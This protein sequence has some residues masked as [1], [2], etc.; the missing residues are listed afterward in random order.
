MSSE[1]ILNVLE[2]IHVA[3]VGLAASLPPTRSPWKLPPADV[4]GGRLQDFLQSCSP[5]CDFQNHNLWAAPPL[6]LLLRVGQWQF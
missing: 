5:A 4:L 6:C 1:K 3:T 2:N